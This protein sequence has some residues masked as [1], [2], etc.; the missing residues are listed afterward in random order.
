MEGIGFTFERRL[1]IE[2]HLLWLRYTGLFLSK[3]N[4]LNNQNMRLENII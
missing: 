4:N 2:L 1:F 3:K